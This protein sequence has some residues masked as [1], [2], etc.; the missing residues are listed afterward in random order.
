[1]KPFRGFYDWTDTG[2]SG[3]HQLRSEDHEKKNI[4]IAAGGG[5]VGAPGGLRDKS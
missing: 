5:P 1:M 4:G 2:V 3:T